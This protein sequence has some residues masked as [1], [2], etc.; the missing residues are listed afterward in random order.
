MTRSVNLCIVAHSTYQEMVGGHGGVIGGIQRQQSFMAKWLAKRGHKVSMLTNH[1]GQPPEQMIDGVRVIRL[2]R[3]DAGLPGIRFFHPRWTSLIAGMKQADADVYYHNVA[4]H[5]TGQVALWCRMN[6]RRFVFS[7]AHDSDCEPALIHLPSWRER[8]LYRYGLLHSDRVISQT[9]T[10]ERMLRDG[11]DVKSTVISMPCPLSTLPPVHRSQRDSPPRIL[12]VGRI[13]PGKRP[14][15]LLDMA[16]RAPEFIFE[17]AGAQNRDSQY[18]SEV[19]ER[20]KKMPNVI[21]H[22]RVPRESMLALYRRALVLCCTSTREGFPNTFLEAWSEGTP[23]VTTFDP[24]D[25]VASRGLGGL[26]T[27]A[28]E[29]LRAIRILAASDSAW[30]TA[31]SNARQH[32]VETYDPEVVMPQFELVFIEASN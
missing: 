17:I 3:E 4:E 23:L 12:W 8:I 6:G 16:E 10:Q 9:L 11:F 24:D 28:E 1:E 32:F 27:N 25:L 26:G 19:L 2:N 15:M 7:T 21:L 5:V 14:H 31:S 18:G 29:L 13:Q 30:S 22:G 20:A